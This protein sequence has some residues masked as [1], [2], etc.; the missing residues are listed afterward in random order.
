LV[1]ELADSNQHAARNE[2]ALLVPR[3]LDASSI[4]LTEGWSGRLNKTEVQS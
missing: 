3:F 4:G 1:I 2:L